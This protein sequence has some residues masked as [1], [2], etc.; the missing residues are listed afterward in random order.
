MMFE[1]MQAFPRELRSDS[2]VVVMNDQPLG[3]A[4]FLDLLA[5]KLRFP[6]GSGRN[7]DALADCLGDLEWL[8]TACIRLVF[9]AIPLRD[10]ADLATFLTILSRSRHSLHRIGV[11]LQPIFRLADR[12]AI[13]QTTLDEPPK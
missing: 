6:H 2:L 1:Y 10:R 9:P 8:S 4:E 7:W 11:T 13:E 12:L 3:K 5:C